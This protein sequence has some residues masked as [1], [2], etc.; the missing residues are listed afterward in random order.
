MLAGMSLLSRLLEAPIDET[1]VED[2]TTFWPRYVALAART[3]RTFDRAVLGGFAAD[4]LAWAFAAGYRSALARLV[5]ELPDDTMAALA[6]SE[7]GGNA[8]KA[9]QTRLS[10]VDGHLVLDGDKTWTTLGPHASVLLVAARVDPEG[11]PRP[12]LRVVRVPVTAA[13]VTITSMHQTPFVPELPHASVQ[14]RGVVIDEAAVLLGDGYDHYVKP[15]RT[16]EDIHVFGA[17]LGHTVRELRRRGQSDTEH[18]TSRAAIERAMAAL[19]ALSSLTELPAP[20]V[21]THIVL[22]GA[23]A[24]GKEAIATL[25]AKLATATDPAA[26]RFRRDRTL[27]SVAGSARAT[28]LEKAWAT[29]SV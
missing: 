6:V 8:P 27:L 5:P 3:P 9:I 26:E 20:S 22:G 21:S 1:V 25:E 4:R 19:A 7:A 16:V 2:V 18:A 14:L 29:I 13:G 10:R 11:S 23:L 17:A 24:V 12:E 28:R 15:F